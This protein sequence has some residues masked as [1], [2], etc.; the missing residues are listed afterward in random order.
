[1]VY[2][3]YDEITLNQIKLSL[4]VCVCYTAQRAYIYFR[5]VPKMFKQEF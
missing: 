4:S 3:I 5:D 1:M 2:Y